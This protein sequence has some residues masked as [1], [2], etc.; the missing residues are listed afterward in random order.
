MKLEYL[1]FTSIEI[2]IACTASNNPNATVCWSS[3]LNHYVQTYS[4]TSLSGYCRFISLHHLH[5]NKDDLCVQRELCG[6]CQNNSN[7]RQIAGIFIEQ[8][9]EH[10]NLGMSQ[11]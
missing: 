8:M 5:G 6:D 4:L 7:M 10:S 1:I 9:S 3:S 2:R 11:D